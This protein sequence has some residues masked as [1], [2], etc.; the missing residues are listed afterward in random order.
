MHAK[1]SPRGLRFFAHDAAN[2][3]CSLTGE[4]IEHRL[5]KSALAAAVRVAGWH[6]ALEVTAPDRSWRADVL[7]TSPDGSRTVAWEAQLA[8][9]HEED[10]LSRTA[11]YNG[12][13]IEVVWVFDQPAQHNV[14]MIEVKIGETGI[15]VAGPIVRLERSRCEADRRCRRYRDLPHPPPCPGHGHWVPAELTLERFVSLVCQDAI[16]RMAIPAP[17]PPGPGEAEPDQRAAWTSPVY[18]RRAQ[19]IHQGEQTTDAA[20]ANERA[21]RWRQQV[22]EQRRR[23]HEAER[24]EANRMALQERQH[25][26]TPFAVQEIASRTGHVPWTL[27]DDFEHAMGVSVMVNGQPA[28]VI[29]PIASRITSE[30]ADRL[31]NAVVYVA[32]ERERSS[33]ARK[34]LPGQRITILSADL[35]HKQLTQPELTHGTPDDPWKTGR[36]AL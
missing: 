26:L 23:Q 5:L 18:V 6:A 22:Q 13:G 14:P 36:K 17:S 34:C 15:T 32:S 35:P 12:V 29:C 20:V 19:A 10:T 27:P 16:R 2:R 3:E 21:E 25:R 33:I 11:R 24:H 9:Q 1:I 31:V 7:A 8:S 30:I 28:A 4:T